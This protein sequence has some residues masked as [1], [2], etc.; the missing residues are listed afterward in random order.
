LEAL[1]ATPVPTSPGNDSTRPDLIA[2]EALLKKAEA[3]LQGQKALRI[4]DPTVSLSYEHEPP[5]GPNSMGFSVSVPLPVWNRY[6]GEIHAAQVA[7]N[8]ALR[9]IQKVKAQIVS[10]RN[11]ATVAYSS[12]VERWKNYTNN[13][14][15]KSAQIRENISFAYKKGGATLLDLL[16]AQRNDN[17]VRLSTVQAGG[18]TLNALA[19]LAAAYGYELEMKNEDTK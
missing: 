19:D 12:V 9:E 1:A 2:A 7:R 17:D 16:S 6:K 14:R 10:E 3:E 18:D 15:P 4:P 13:V 11:Q 5:G 8:D